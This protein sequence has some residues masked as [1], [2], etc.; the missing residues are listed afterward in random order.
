MQEPLMH[1]KRTHPLITSLVG[2]LAAGMLAS[3]RAAEEPKEG[4][5][6]TV[7]GGVG[8]A[9][10]Y[11]GSKERY[12]SLIPVLDIAYKTG[13]LVLAPGLLMWTP[14]ETDNYAFGTLVTYDFGRREK[15]GSS[16]FNSGSDSLKGLGDVKGTAEYGVHG[17]VGPVNAVVRKA[18]SGSGHGGVIAEIGLEVPFELSDRLSLS[19]TPSVAF[20]DKR[21][22]QSYFGV[23]ETQ[24]R[25][26]GKRAFQAGAG[27]KGYAVALGARYAVTERWAVV[28]L[29]SVGRRAGDLGRSPVVEKRGQTGA[30][31]TLNYS[32]Q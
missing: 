10:R 29:V 9:P 22:A 32:F 17:R 25:N 24:A 15:D 6:V 16:R 20:M 21:Y 19:V 8:T 7:G 18:P 3:A 1:T 26:S 13:S 5:N 4:W 23:T 11:E 12:T 30:A 28:G 2:L 14:V 27:T 31:L